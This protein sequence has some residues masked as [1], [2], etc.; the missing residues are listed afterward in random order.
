M[1]TQTILDKQRAYLWPNHILYYTDPLPLSHGDGLY[2][3]DTD[4]NRYLDF[5]GGI[6][7]TS[8]GHN[9]PHVV[10]RVREQVGKLIHSSTLYPNE[11]HV[12]L[13]EKLAE[14]TPGRLQMS[15]FTN[16]GSEANETAI[17]A[18]QTYTDNREIVALRHAYS[19]RT[20]LT[21]SVT[22]HSTW[23]VGK[24]FSPDIKHAINP[25]C[26]RCPLK[27]TYPACG[28][29]CAQDVEDVIRTTTSGKIAAFMAE[30]IQ[31]VGG[32]I[33]PPD[34]YFQIAVEIARRYGGV[35]ICDEVQTGFGRTGTHWFG[36]THW[37]VEPE[38]MTMAKGIANGMPLANTITVPEVAQAMVGKGLTIST[39]GGNPVSTAAAL[40]TLEAMEEA[41]GPERFAGLGARLRG[42]LDRLGEKY[43][44]IGD[45]RGKGL[46]QGIEMV[47]D[48][49]SKEPA[50][51]AVAQLFEETRARGLLI[52]KGGLYGNVIRISPP[53]TVSEAQID[54][55]LEIL[56][57]ALG[58]VHETQG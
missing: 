57:Y 39:F 28:V 11:N 47:T 10:G 20:S 30:P 54:Q 8:V 46:M 35:F 19:G 7:T 34:E 40:G 41:G 17:V 21:M 58:I 33:T 18:A 4:G 23:K 25:Y 45:V 12:T 14:R 1:E 5:F 29:A 16:S 50:P 44:L 24:S 53:L 22:A 27:L 13:A 51:K 43:P 42:G 26:Y 6:L 37:G 38:I 52:G 49:R 32:F 56:D 48:R 31:G 9:N 3:W 15:Y 55:A 2:V 36:I